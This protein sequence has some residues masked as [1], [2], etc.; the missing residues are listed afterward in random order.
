MPGIAN[1]VVNDG[2][3]T[4]VAHT[5]TP[6]KRNFIP[7]GMASNFRDL[8]ASNV[9]VADTLVIQQ[10]DMKNMRK[11]R[12]RLTRPRAVSETVNGVT[13]VRKADFASVEVVAFVPNTWAT[14]DAKDMRVM[15]ANALNNT[16]VVAGVDNGEQIL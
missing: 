14:A 11:V 9:D 3:T 12:V 7:G 15:M 13:S 4:P 5:F 10:S 6:T 1:V 8:S 2:K 16:L